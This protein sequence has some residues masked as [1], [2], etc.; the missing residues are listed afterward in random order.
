MK[1]LVV[2]LFG[3]CAL[4]RAG[5]PAPHV[6]L[7]RSGAVLADLVVLEHGRQKPLDTLAREALR[8]VIGSARIGGQH[9]VAT[10]LSLAWEPARWDD[11]AFLAVSG[12]DTRAL[13]DGA[14]RVSPARLR[15]WLETTS[16]EFHAQEHRARSH[17][18]MERIRQDTQRLWNRVRGLYAAVDALDALPRGF[19]IIPDPRDPAHVWL[20]IAEARE[21]VAGGRDVLQEAVDA[22][23]QCN[24]AFLDA[25]EERFAQAAAALLAAQRALAR[26]LDAPILSESMVRFERMYYAYD[27]RWVGLV[28]AVAAAALSIAGLALRRPVLKRSAGAAMILA[29]CWNTW[30]IAGHTVIAGRLPLKNL[31]E[32]YLV[33]LFFLP[34]IGLV[35][36]ALLRS[37][38]YGAVAMVLTVVGFVG[39]F[40]LKSEGYDIAP[41]V[42]ILHSPWREVHILT[43]MLSYALLLVAAGLDVTFL[44]AW[45]AGRRRGAAPQEGPADIAGELHR[46][47]Y[48]MLAW[49]F[50][51]LTIGIATGAAWANASWGR[52]WGWDAK[53]VWATVAW[54]IYALYLHVRIFF[55]APSCVLV[56]IN[57]VGYAA[58]LFTYFG[59]SY[60][61]PGLHSYS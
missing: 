6:A 50:L 13:F 21:A 55:R 61:L 44:G 56:A 41:L 31:N 52:Y 2:C 7:A 40:K 48:T 12:R 24:A 14:E 43:I 26:G 59:V 9:P 39:S 47:A 4:S 3:V 23:E 51:F 11:T 38:L 27:F 37:S 45:A 54:V 28:L 29:A 15:A 49:G 36:N 42:A 8:R 33:V 22:A 34:V 10:Y 46:N 18:D 30:I 58:I 5:E 60:W 25:G 35:L 57:V 16:R 32:V 19:R 53:E 17:E 20:T 1:Y